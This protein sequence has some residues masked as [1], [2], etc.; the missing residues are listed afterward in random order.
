M[1][2]HNCFLLKEKRLPIKESSFAV[3]VVC[4][5]KTSEERFPELYKKPFVVFVHN[6]K[7]PREDG[8]EKPEGYGNPGGG[9]K[10][11]E[12][13]EQA[14]VRETKQ[15]TALIVTRFE[16]V[17]YEHSLAIPKP[18]GGFEYTRCGRLGDAMRDNGFQPEKGSVMEYLMKTDLLDKAPMSPRQTLTHTFVVEVDWAASE[19]QDLFLLQY[20]LNPQ[21]LE[22]GIVLNIPP[23]L[24][25][26]LGI[27]EAREK[28]NKTQEIDAIGLFPVSALQS[29]YK[30][31]DV[32]TSH[33]RRAERAIADAPFKATR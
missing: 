29:L 20:A 27:V 23:E 8:S 28:P 33:A 15:E 26:Q 24:A 6:T 10:S 4:F 31:K 17:S 2:E 19:L 13:S 3:P 11:G 32:Y 14:V 25:D 5:S 30:R 9:V 22:S 16:E 18:E 1:K 21:P 7:E 12:T